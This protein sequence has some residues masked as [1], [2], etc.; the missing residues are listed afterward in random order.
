MTT[1]ARSYDVPPVTR[2][3]ALLRYIAAGNRCR[4][5]SKASTALGINRTTLIRLLHTLEREDMV[6]Q[7]MHGGG[8]TLGYGVLELASGLTG[9]RDIVRMSRP[10]LAK[11]AQRTGLSAH[12]GVLSGTDIIV[13]VREAPDVQLVSNIREGVR[14]PAHATVMGRMILG[15]MPHDAVRALYRGRDLPAITAQTAQTFDDLF[16]QIDRD[17]A[18]GLAWSVANFEEGI[19][20]CSAAV[21]DHSDRAIAAISISGPQ[22]AF[23]KDS[24]KHGLIAAEIRETA[25]K[26]SALMGHHEDCIHI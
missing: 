20:S 6:E 7:D 2:A 21:R 13:V 16:A 25:A 12:L 26:L 9:S 4:N 14:L 24:D 8:Y 23:E 11:L 19:G 10:L 17:R 3:M 1:D 22:A 18:A 5:I 15:H